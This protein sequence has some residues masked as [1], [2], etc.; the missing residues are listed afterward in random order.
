VD[1]RHVVAPSIGEVH[2]AGD[3]LV[4]IVV[5]VF[6]K[7]SF[8]VE[9]L[10]S[11]LAQ[12]YAPTELIV[13]DDGSTDDSLS[14]VHQALAATDARVIAVTNGGVSSARNIGFRNISP[15]A[16]YVLFLDADDRL[17]P[18]AVGRL[19]GQ[20]EANPAAAACYCEVTFIDE[21]GTRLSDV[22]DQIRWT[23]TPFGR[24]RLGPSEPVTPLD[25][26]WARF[27]A[28]PSTLLIRRTAFDMVSGWD[29][30]LC[31]PARQFHAEDKDL[32]IQLAL[33]GELHHLD[34][35]LVEYRVLPSGHKDA[36][37]LGLKALDAKWSAAPL[38]G[39]QRRRVRRAMWFDARVRLLDSATALT[40]PG[41]T[42]GS[43]VARLR[44][45]AKSTARFASTGV[46]IRRAGDH[47]RKAL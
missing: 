28:L 14:V 7:S 1:A 34:D 38:S 43:L 39:T 18:E 40:T 25:A 23:R 17:V 30:N 33:V 32:A 4:S 31:R 20:L 46:R 2:A 6:N 44:T 21:H 5:S 12:S 45:L 36:L 9:T 19:V 22:P 13:V 3:P 8:V 26:I 27:A 37:Y 10:T 42:S 15:N 41:P 11:A 24:R 35:R 16:A 29:S 47:S